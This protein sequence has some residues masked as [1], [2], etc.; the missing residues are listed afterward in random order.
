M[1]SLTKTIEYG[2][3]KGLV[4]NENVYKYYNDVYEDTK[5]IRDMNAD[6]KVLYISDKS[7]WLSGVQ[8]CASYSPLCYS[9]SSSDFSSANSS[10]GVVPIH[11]MA[12]SIL[13]TPGRSTANR[14]EPY[15]CITGSA[16][17]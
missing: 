11:S 15:I 4:V 12:D 17:P 10:K 2:P 9:I 3:C 8:R 6:T 14:S 5:E 13:S 7:L 16:T 1:K